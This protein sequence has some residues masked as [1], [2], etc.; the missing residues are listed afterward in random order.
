M[1]MVGWKVLSRWKDLLEEIV[2]EINDEF[3]EEGEIAD[4]KGRRRIR[5]KRHVSRAR[6]NRVLKLHLPENDGYTTL[7][8][9]LMAQAGRLMNQGEAIEYNG[10]RFIIERVERRRIRR[11][12]L[13]FSDPERQDTLAIL[14]TAAT[15]L[16]QIA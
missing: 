2:G 4:R 13:I 9:F 11:V 7:A 14:I 8:G 5:F 16:G 10:A 3:D 6:R 15:S 1:S 12:R